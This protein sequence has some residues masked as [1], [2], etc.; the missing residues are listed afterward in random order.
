[1]LRWT[2][3]THINITEEYLVCFYKVLYFW[4]VFL[5]SKIRINKIK[6]HVYDLMYNWNVQVLVFL[7]YCSEHVFCILNFSHTDL[8][9]E[10]L[11]NNLNKEFFAINL[12]LK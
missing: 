6:I 11:H 5:N 2:K 12:S 9:N 3:Y 1:M 4:P 8:Q 10:L 7:L